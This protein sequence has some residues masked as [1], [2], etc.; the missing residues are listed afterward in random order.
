MIIYFIEH[1][2]TH[3]WL[4]TSLGRCIDIMWD[5]SKT[6]NYA[7]VYSWTSDPHQAKQY[8]SKQQAEYAIDSI[9][10]QSKVFNWFEFDKENENWFTNENRDNWIITEHEFVHH[11]R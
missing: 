7:T 5:S 4:M 3:E 6:P 10:G 11:R 1:K 9:W 8:G 2:E